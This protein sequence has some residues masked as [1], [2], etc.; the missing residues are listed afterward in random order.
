MAAEGSAFAGTSS[1]GLYWQ[2]RSVGFEV[3]DGRR[4]RLLGHVQAV[5]QDR[6]GS[7]KSLVVRRPRRRGPLRL[8]CS[9]VDIV[10]PWQQVLVVTP[11][12]RRRA[13]SLGDGSLKV[14]AGAGRVAAATAPRAALA[15]GIAAWVYAALVV[16]LGRIVLRG[17][18]VVWRAAVRVGRTVGRTA[19]R[20]QP[21][22]RLAE[23]GHRLRHHLAKT[24]PAGRLG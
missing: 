21:G 19:E 7:A 3:R 20:A 5:R 1:V 6:D 2:S 10:E 11:P 24:T 22:T 14:A 23:Y 15:L 16:S 12:G 8:E 4:G 17:A 18:A 9:C 13:R